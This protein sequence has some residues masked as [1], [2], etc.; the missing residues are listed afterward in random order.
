[1]GIDRDNSEVASIFD[2]R[3]PVVLQ[4]IENVINEAKKYHVPVSICGQAPSDFPEI[5]E[6]LVKAGIDS[7]SVNPDAVNRTRDIIYN[8]EKDLKS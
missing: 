5:V 1:L 8:I 6:K 3:N 4:V 7:V 2:E